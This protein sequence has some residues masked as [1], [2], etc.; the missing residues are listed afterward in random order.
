MDKI[1]TPD[2]QFVDGTRR[3]PGTPVP[4]WWLNQ[5][6]D[7][8]AD[9]ISAA[10]I[11]L[12]KGEKQLLPAILKILAQKASAV[13]GS[14]QELRA[15]DYSG[16][17]V[18]NLIGYHVQYPGVGGGILVRMS[19]VNHDNGG[20]IFADAQGNSFGRVA[21]SLVL[22]HFGAIGSGQLV[23]DASGASLDS[24]AIERF[25]DYATKSGAAKKCHL[26]GRYVIDRIIVLK[27]HAYLV[28]ASDYST[29][30]IK[31]AGFNGHAVVS[32]NF[33]VLKGT[34]ALTDE[35]TPVDFGIEYIK[36]NGQYLNAAEDAYINTDGGGVYI[37]GSK[38]KLKVIV[39]NVAGVGI[40][41]D[42]AGAE[43]V[44][45]FRAGYIDVRSDTTRDENFI[46]KGPADLEIMS[47]RARRAGAV[48]TTD[49]KRWSLWATPNYPQKNRVDAVVFDDG[50]EVQFLHSWGHEVGYGVVHNAGRLNADL[51]I[52][53]SALGGFEATGSAY[54]LIDKLRCHNIKG[55][56]AYQDPPAPSSGSMPSARFGGNGN[57]I[58]SI[59]SFQRSGS[60][61]TG[62]ADLHVENGRLIVGAL[63]IIGHGKAGHGVVHNGGVLEIATLDVDNI[64][65][66]SVDGSGSAAIVGNASGLYSYLAVR[67]F[68]RNSDVGIKKN[69]DANIENI[70]LQMQDVA[71]PWVGNQRKN[72]GQ[73]WK[74]DSVGAVN[75]SSHFVGAI[76]FDPQSVEM[77]K[78]KIAH[79]LLYAPNINSVQI[80]VADSPTSIVDSAAEFAQVVVYELNETYVTVGIKLR[81]AGNAAT[82][83]RVNINITI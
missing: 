2:G 74:I 11:E 19:G 78:V 1:N 68:I 28:G 72:P 54:G 57:F 10:G 82:T 76:E 64:K 80:S 52:S 61:Q 18:I 14:I 47:I 43:S 55:G 71:T 81:V 40:Y 37:Y 35:R 69:K 63:S 46:F 3:I 66:L 27:T 73:K 7:E 15:G 33:D 59:L 6:Q 56:V 9:V 32:D 53:E 29:E 12:Q 30:I 31:K 45:R 17:N 5:T 23:E 58:V 50:C 62:H 60:G 79:G 49:S 16:V 22:E 34:Q 24:L 36:I 21:S 42:G 41:L 77:Q 13:V 8:F 26:P 20:T 4:A 51:I 70:D 83:P 75:K 39:F 38:Y 67:G 44:D 48:A 65:G 25:V